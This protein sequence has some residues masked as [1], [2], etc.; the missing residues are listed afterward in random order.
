MRGFE[1]FY[2]EFSELSNKS[3]VP[4]IIAE[5]TVEIFID[6]EFRLLW[7]TID[8]Y[9]PCVPGNANNWIEG[10]HAKHQILEILESM[11][12]HTDDRLE[13]VNPI[14]IALLMNI[15]VR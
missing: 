11:K 7:T 2:P 10:K 5:C 8:V 12:G 15:A 13:F 3:I 1:R 6:F 14:E 9:F 4:G